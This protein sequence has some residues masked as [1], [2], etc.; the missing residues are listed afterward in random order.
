M[1]ILNLVTPEKR[2]VT[3]QEIEEVI[4]PGFRGELDILPGHAPLVTTLHSGI[5]RF[6]RKGSQVMEKVAVSWGYCEVSSVGV[7][8]LAE[9]AET[10][11]QIDHERAR[12]ALEKS[13]K[14]LG[15]PLG[16]EEF[17]KHQ[18]KADRARWRIEL[19][20]NN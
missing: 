5:L 19:S 10:A 13:L 14:S 11:D 15:G 2:L 9:T 20:K 18:R 7:Q 12:V 3:G 17:K 4:V 6:R 16:S 8:I 1:F